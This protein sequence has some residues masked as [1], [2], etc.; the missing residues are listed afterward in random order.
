LIATDEG[1]AYQKLSQVFPHEHVDHKAHEHEYV[2]G[3]VHMNN[4]VLVAAE[5][6]HHGQL[7]QGQQKYLPLYLAEFSFRHNHC[8]DTDIFGSI[9][10]GC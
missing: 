10:A 8:K 1:A 5:A 6:R 3:N 7:S 9:V 2:R 4:I